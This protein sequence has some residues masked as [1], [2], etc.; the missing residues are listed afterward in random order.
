MYAALHQY[1]AQYYRP[2][3]VRELIKTLKVPPR[4]RPS[5]PDISLWIPDSAPD[6]SAQANRVVRDREAT[7]ILNL[8][9]TFPLD[10]IDSVT[11]K[12]NELPVGEFQ[13]QADRTWQAP[14]PDTAAVADAH[15]VRGI[16]KT[17]ESPPREFLTE[18][19]FRVQPDAPA[20]PERPPL[21]LAT[22]LPLNKSAES[23]G[24]SRVDVEVELDRLPTD[25]ETVKLSINDEEVETPLEIVSAPGR[26]VIARATVTLDDRKENRIQ[27]RT[28][29]DTAS[30][31]SEFKCNDRSGSSN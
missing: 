7:A 5:E 27:A 14:L 11:L 28:A 20:M 17:T 30:L 26:A 4:P 10:M 23:L 19:S 3:L 6:P 24:G 15:R 18:L 2:F 16:V 31:T 12:L 1:R 22:V 13:L 29:D 25:G 9:P 21:P 8:D